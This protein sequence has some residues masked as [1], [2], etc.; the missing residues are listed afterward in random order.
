MLLLS[1]FQV[2]LSKYSGSE[3]VVV[4]SPIAG[5]RTGEVEELI[6]FFINTLV[7]RTD[8]FLQL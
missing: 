3:D 4:G 7:L 6:G 5:A 1:V 8:P 2:L